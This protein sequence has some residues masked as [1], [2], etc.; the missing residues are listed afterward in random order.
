MPGAIDWEEVGCQWLGRLLSMH[1]HSQDH[2]ATY[3]P[4][5]LCLPLC[6]LAHSTLI[7]VL[8]TLVV[9]RPLGQALQVLGLNPAESL[10]CRE[11]GDRI[12]LQLAWWT[13]CLSQKELQPVPSVSQGCAW[14]REG[15][16]QGL[17]TEAGRGAAWLL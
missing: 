1:S 9:V 2:P 15:T 11:G 5:P 10:L 13:T 4:Q 14:G 7:F 8:E 17:F 12:K 6:G 3:V 16:H